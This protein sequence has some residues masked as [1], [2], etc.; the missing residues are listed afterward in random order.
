MGQKNTPH[1]QPCEI[2][3]VWAAACCHKIKLPVS[4]FSIITCTWAKSLPNCLLYTRQQSTA[5]YL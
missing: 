4:S 1:G 3:S 5:P 2:V